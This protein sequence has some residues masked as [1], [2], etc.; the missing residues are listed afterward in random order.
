MIK[1]TLRDLTVTTAIAGAAP[2]RSLAYRR[3]AK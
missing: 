2:N 3:A 1:T